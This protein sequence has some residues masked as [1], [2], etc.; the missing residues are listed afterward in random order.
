[1]SPF[2]TY[3][4]Q[5]VGKA[6]RLIADQR[7][8]YEY[9]DEGNLSRKL[10]HQDGTS[11]LFSYDF[12][13]RMTSVVTTSA[14]GSELEHEEYTYDTLNRRVRVLQAGRTEFIGFDG[15]NPL[16]KLDGGGSVL[17]RRLYT[18]S[19]DGILADELGGQTRWC[20]RDLVGTTRDLVGDSGAV[21]DHYTYDSFGRLLKQSSPGVANDIQFTGREFDNNGLGYFRA[22][23]YRS[24]LGAFVSEDPLEPFVYQYA[25]NNPLVF[26]DPRGEGIVE[27][28]SLR[29]Y[30]RGI[31][32]TAQSPA[33]RAALLAVSV[34]QGIKV[35]T[36]FLEAAGASAN[37]IVAY[38]EIFEVATVIRRILAAFGVGF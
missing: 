21:I 11:T 31:T 27:D 12:R 18:R 2:Y 26:V 6:Y 7:F 24:D 25:H 32:L 19:L 22:R 13:N 4:Y 33:L 1:L 8:S 15:L 34:A 29:L 36:E 38:Q 14:G 37:E 17:S 35:P 10:D 28:I 5:T 30:V 9:D 3:S 16:L 20:L 23:Y